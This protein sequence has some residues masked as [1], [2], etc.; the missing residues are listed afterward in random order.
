[1]KSELEIVKEINRMAG[2]VRSVDLVMDMITRHGHRIFLIYGLVLWFA[3]GEG[4]AE[5]RRTCVSAWAA[6]CFCSCLSFLIGKIWKRKRPF[7]KDWRIWNFTGH[8]ANSSFP[9]NHAMNSAAVALQ[10][11]KDKT[12]GSPCMAVLAGI[13]AFSRLFAGLHYPSDLL[14]GAAIAIF[15]H[16]VMNHS[17]L[18]K[19]TEKTAGFLSF[20]SDTLWLRIKGR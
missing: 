10:L 17:V 16:K 15:M 8:K 5:R 13:I 2:G 6:V 20:L 14:G 18:R 4:R 1:M 12:P 3:R 19:L 9:S 7:T 11:L